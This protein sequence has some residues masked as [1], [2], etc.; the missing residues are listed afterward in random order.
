MS[1]PEGVKKRL[2]RP[3]LAFSGRSE[4]HL[5]VER[6]AFVSETDCFAGLKPIIEP[7]RHFSLVL[8]CVDSLEMHK[9]ACYTYIVAMFV[10]K[11]CLHL[12]QRGWR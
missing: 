8:T 6:P 9:Q 2:G 5:S 1:L 10:Y 4:K 3:D 7:Q 12:C 11:V